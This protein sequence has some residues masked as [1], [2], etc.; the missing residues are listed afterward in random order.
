MNELRV[1]LT[2]S[3]GD[4]RGRGKA[5]RL[6]SASRLA[7]EAPPGGRFKRADNSSPHALTNPWDADS[8]G[9]GAV[10]CCALGLAILTTVPGIAT[11]DQVNGVDGK[12][13]PKIASSLTEGTGF[14][15]H[16]YQTAVLQEKQI[17]IC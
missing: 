4:G 11:A 5:L 9:L 7:W 12:R 3:E 8:T 6:L 2:A 10:L 16:D 1:Y 13:S 17:N 15:I 14:R